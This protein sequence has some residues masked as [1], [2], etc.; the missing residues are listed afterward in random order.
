[1]FMGISAANNVRSVNSLADAKRVLRDCS[2]TPTGRDRV[3]KEFGYPVGGH[4]KSVTWARPTDDGGV[5]FRLY[6]TDV[7]TYLGDGSVVIEN[8]GTVS[9]TKFADT[10]APRTLHL[11]HPTTTRGSEGGHKGIRYHC[12]SEYDWKTARVCIGDAVRFVESENGAWLPDATTLDDIRVPELDRKALPAIAKAYNLRDFETWLSMAPMHLDIEHVEWDLDQ[13]MKALATRDF[14]TAAA[15][16]PTIIEP[17]GF[18]T[19]ERMKPLNIAVAARD[20]HVTMGSFRKLKL[21]L[22][23]SLGAYGT[24]TVKTLPDREHD[25][26][27][28]LNNELRKL[29]IWNEWGIQ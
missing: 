2:L 4:S 1:M 12:A 22:W 16:L 25:R 9:T 7:V 6:D 13:C 19:A 29:D 3:A 20:E 26:I 28:Q 21:A 24:T 10:F 18:G 27:R 17:S 14:T 5:A 11:C 15:Y 8:F 23:D